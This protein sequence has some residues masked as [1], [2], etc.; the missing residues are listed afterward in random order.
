[1]D[2]LPIIEKLVGILLKELP[3]VAGEAAR[4]QTD[5]LAQRA[6]LRGLMNMHNP[7]KLLS[8]EY[9]KLQ[10]M[11]L[12]DELKEKTITDCRLLAPV[13]KHDLMR[14]FNGDITCL[15]V[16]AIVNSASN[17]LLGC[18]VAA[19]NCVDNCIHSAA[20]LQLRF[21]CQDL[22][23]KQGSPERPG[24]AKITPGFNLPCP[25]VIHTI[26]PSIAWQV[27]SGNEE[28]LRKCYLSCLKLAD[29][30][31]LK[32]IAFPCISTG[33]SRFPH[34]QAGR[35][36]VETVYKYLNETKSSLKV[37]FVTKTEVDKNIYEKLL[38][39]DPAA[40][41]EDLHPFFNVNLF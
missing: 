41:P 19:H 25:Y 27:N 17:N 15:K 30:K 24:E 2:R 39:P 34:S 20:G 35:I 18:F 12:Q 37:V 3:S 26:G 16:D 22:I 36:A 11:L 38:N 40:K 31:G 10:D 13:K 9:F 23:I 8:E 7:Q 33:D 14:H 1:M 6:L 32:S 29:E 5:E 21:F 28:T 4:F